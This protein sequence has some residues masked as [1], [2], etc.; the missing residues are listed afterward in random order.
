MNILF[1]NACP[2]KN[3]RTQL[4]TKYLLSKLKGTVHERNLATTELLPLT[5]ETIALR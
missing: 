2:R 1:V 3:S 4:L 5:E